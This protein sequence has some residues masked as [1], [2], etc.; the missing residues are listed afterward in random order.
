MLVV[1]SVSV[2]G[3][4]NPHFVPRIH[5]LLQLRHPFL[6]LCLTQQ[7]QQWQWQECPRQTEFALIKIDEARLPFAQALSDTM[8]QQTNIPLKI[9]EPLWRVTVLQ[10]QQQSALIISMHHSICDGLSAASLLA[11]WLE[12]HEQVARQEVPDI[13]RLAV[14]ACV[15]EALGLD[16]FSAD[17]NP[18]ATPI[19]PAQAAVWINQANLEQQQV[20]KLELLSFSQAQ[21]QGLLA[22]SRQHQVSLTIAL[23]CA[24]AEVA[25]SLA[26]SP[27]DSVSAGGNANVRPIVEPPVRS[28]RIGLLC[29]DVFF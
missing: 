24:A 25:A 22:L 11:E 4:I 3:S 27:T 10:G 12:R 15:H 23:Y 7:D 18:F 8:Q 5:Q 17:Q 29:I 19:N 21:T 16:E 20:N 2:A 14:R 9:G 13:Q 1:N 26:R 28:P 6:S